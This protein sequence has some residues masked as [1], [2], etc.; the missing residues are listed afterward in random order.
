MMIKEGIK[1]K[2]FLIIGPEGSGKKTLCRLWAKQLRDA[3]YKAGEDF[4]VFN[5]NIDALLSRQDPFGRVRRVFEHFGNLHGH[6]LIIM[7]DIERFFK[8]LKGIPYQHQIYRLF[9]KEIKNSQY[10]WFATAQ[11]IEILDKEAITAF[12]SIVPMFYPVTKERV[13][14]LDAVIRRGGFRRRKGLD[15]EYLASKT[16]YW[17]GGELERLVVGY[18][19]GGII[20][21]GDMDRGIE[22]YNRMIDK[23][24]RKSIE[25]GIARLV[26]RNSTEKEFIEFASLKLSDSDVQPPKVVDKLE[27]L[28]RGTEEIKTMVRDYGE[29]ILVNTER[30][31]HSINHINDNTIEI[32]KRFREI[33]DGLDPQKREEQIQNYLEKMTEIATK[34]LS[35]TETD[36]LNE[37]KRMLIDLFSETWTKLQDES[38]KFLLTTEVVYDSIKGNK[39]IDYSPACL[40]LTKA[41]ERELFINLVAVSQDYCRENI[42]PDRKKWPGPLRQ[43]YF[44]LGQLSQI[45][46]NKKAREILKNSIKLK[47]KENTLDQECNLEKLIKGSQHIKDEFRNK[48]A[49]MEEISL[50]IAQDCRKYILLK[51]KFLIEFMNMLK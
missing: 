10:Y 6:V 41:L 30:I 18:A 51:E 1:Q 4:E 34:K 48:I 50:A 8:E 19:I 37:K 32:K 13:G 7:D 21:T 25:D 28:M 27:L 14:I 20:S 47:C 38:K 35:E 12:D 31:L 16:Q 17:T 2:S 33:I 42:G 44:M 40:P 29:R 5:F 24:K 9:L 45:Y 3:C 36:I 26:L 23:A 15:L 49:H 22:N 39:Y 46:Q 43:K 11:E